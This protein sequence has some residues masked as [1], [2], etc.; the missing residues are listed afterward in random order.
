MSE[1][2]SIATDRVRLFWRGALARDTTGPEVRSFREAPVQ[3]QVESEAKRVALLEETTY[4]VWA[5]SLNR[6]SI[7][8]RHAD[9][10]VTSALRY[11]SDGRIATGTVR[12][13]SH[14][15][16]MRILVLVG[17][18][19][20]LAITANV[21]PRKVTEDQVLQMLEEVNATWAGLSF[22]ALRPTHDPRTPGL[23]DPSMPVWLALLRATMLPLNAALQEIRRRPVEEIVR[24]HQR[25]RASRATRSDATVRASVRRAGG[26]IPEVLDA[27]PVRLTLDTPSHRWLAA[28]LHRAAMHLR[29][30]VREE[31]RR[32]PTARRQRLIE[33]LEGYRR[34]L[35][36]HLRQEPLVEA[37]GPSPS[38]PPL[39][40][41]RRPAYAAAYTALRQL[42]GGLDRAEGDIR[43]ALLD[44]AS[45]YETWCALTLVRE[46]AEVL[47]HPG[48]VQPFGLHRAG[49]EVRL[50]RGRSAAIRIEGR[51]VQAEIT[52]APRFA[53]PKALLAQR[54]D[55][56]LTVRGTSTR[57]IVLDA[58]YRRDEV[59]MRYG[60]A[61]PP[62]DA[63]GALH[64]YRDAIRAPDG[65]AGWIDEA[66]AL[67]PPADDLAAFERSKLWIGLADI[68]VG[69][70]P[71]VPGQTEWL[72]RWVERTLLERT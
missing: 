53:S 1:Q 32:P 5:E 55:L 4:T 24:A 45:L 12:F 72:R 22:A 21:T 65:S 3:V 18:H 2:V 61:G 54:P 29:R 43:P 23:G 41:R 34:Q 67:F 7:E 8:I 50:R 66:L 16:R 46:A 57:R 35:E 68:G 10:V 15:G 42:E 31:R 64:R 63:I 48:P 19:V 11:E 36:R 39:A 51:G 9:P 58:K 40:L 6:E 49:V 60:V 13:G 20:E 70:I 28:R 25:V 30:L 38:V 62:A 47:G 56:L 37:E 14:I 71:L 69:A 59:A 52:Y 27:R 33:E 26:V 44:L 17:G